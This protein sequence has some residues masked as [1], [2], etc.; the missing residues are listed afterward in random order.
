MDSAVRTFLEA[1]AGDKRMDDA[2][3][4]VTMIEAITGEPARMWGGSIVGAGRY[5]YRYE[6]GRE[7][8]SCMLGFSPRSAEFALYMHGL[9]LD[10]AKEAAAPLLAR[11]G[12]YRQGMGCLYL[13]S[14]D[15]I[16]TGV[17]ADLMRLAVD[18]LRQRYP[19]S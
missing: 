3:A 11:L 19:E 7:G 5:H 13:K 9:T 14:L 2:I 15:G 6:S 17:L 1:K 10:E 16:D 8:E 12:R 18:V 4:F